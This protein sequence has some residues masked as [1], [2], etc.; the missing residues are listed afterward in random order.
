V[1][2]ERRD[3]WI[4]IGRLR[5]D[6]L[7]LALHCPIS[8]ERSRSN[9]R[10]A[11]MGVVAPLGPTAGTLRRRVGRPWRGTRGSGTSL[12]AHRGIWQTQPRAP[13]RRGSTRGRCTRRGGLTAA[14]G[15]SD[16]Q[17]RANQCSTQGNRAPGRLLTLRGNVGGTGQRRRHKEAT[18]RR[19]RSSGR[20]RTTLVSA[21]RTNQRRGGHTKRCP[22]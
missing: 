14:R 10:G 5:L 11:D 12:G 6:P 4:W 8:G 16:E 1:R 20:A 18:G 9:G 19:W 22:E 21:D 7:G 15:N 3:G 17:L 2:G 13:R